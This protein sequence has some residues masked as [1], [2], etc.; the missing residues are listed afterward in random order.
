M[1]KT[2]Y[3]YVLRYFTYTAVFCISPLQ[4]LMAQMQQPDVEAIQKATIQAVVRNLEEKHVQPKT[5]D[6]N[7][8]RIIWKKYL[9]S[10]DPNKDLLLKSDFQQLKK[11][12]LSIDDELHNGSVAFFTAAYQV[13]QKRLAT[14]AAGYQKILSVP[15]DFN[16]KE[17]VQLNGSLLEYA[18]N[19][20]ELNRLWQ[21]KAKYLVLQRLQDQD[22]DKAAGSS[23]EKEAR[24]KVDKWLAGTFKNLTGP[25]ALNDRFSQYLNIVTLEVDPHTNYFAP[26]QTRNISSH[27]AKRFFGVGLEL[28]EKDGDVF[29]KGLRPGGMALKSGLV[30]VNDRILSISDP[31]GKMVDIAGKAIIEVADLI[32]G[33]QGTEVAMNLL[34]VNGQEKNSII[35]KG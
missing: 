20:A 29:V 3:S 18:A 25:S 23:T 14:A 2:R 34:K 21:K 32:R 12:E 28:Q 9:E 24:A 15:F 8:S 35:K 27:M 1:N 31:S 4:S 26:V 5:I 16:K 7:F 13:Y 30:D 33:D 19:Q 22:K 10:L 17:T 11:Y 6:D